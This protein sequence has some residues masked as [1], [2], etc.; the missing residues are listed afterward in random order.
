[1]LKYILKRTGYMILTFVIITCMC[2]VLIRMLDPIPLPP[3]DPVSLVVDARREALGYN[4]PMLVQLGIFA[5][6]VLTEFDF[7]ISEVLYFGQDV[8]DIFFEKLPATIAVNL[9]SIVLSIPPG[10]RAGRH[11]RPVQGQMAGSHHQHRD[12][13]VHFRAQLCLRLL[14]SVS[15]VR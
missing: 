13:G 7:G 15:A 8:A 9:Y 3:D 14:D 12:H 11:R 10:H 2:F 5:K 4:E 1:M 6:N